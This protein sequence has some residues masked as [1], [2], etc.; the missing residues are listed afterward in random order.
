M[1]LRGTFAPVWHRATPTRRRDMSVH[2]ISAVILDEHERAA[3]GWVTRLVPL[4]YSHPAEPLR[5]TTRR[6]VDERDPRLRVLKMLAEPG[7]VTHSK[8]A[9]AAQVLAEVHDVVAAQGSPRWWLRLV[10]ARRKP[11]EDDQKTAQAMAD[12]RVGQL[13]RVQAAQDVVAAALT[14]LGPRDNPGFWAA[15]EAGDI[16]LG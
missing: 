11:T 1:P 3:L 13:P 15:V 2:V 16:D 12:E 10:K 7:L 9:L 6:D 8:A 14:R 5:S 4:A